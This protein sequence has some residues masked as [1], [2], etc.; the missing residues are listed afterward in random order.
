MFDLTRDYSCAVTAGPEH[1]DRGLRDGMRWI[2]VKA[3]ELGGQPLVFAPGRSNIRD[4]PL[5]EQ[6]T[7]LPGVAV[8]TW[9]SIPEWRG[10]PV[11]AAWPNRRKLGE[12]ADDSR[13]SALV[14]V[15]W[16]PG[17]LDSWIAA[18]NPEPLGPAVGPTAASSSSILDPVVL[19][20]LETLT[21][22]VNHAN[23]LAG[24]LDRRDAVAV[25]RTLSNAGYHL[26]PDAVYSWAFEHGWPAR[27]AERLRQL[28]ADF[29]A[30]KQPHMKGQFP[31]RADI[32]DTWRRA[33]RENR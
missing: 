30:G 29:E 13:T 8:G 25:L 5:L 33:A 10:G 6:F 17:E 4:V 15:P 28:A 31:F 1:G 20:G 21:A 3:R 19:Q 24:A 18:A 26:S 11:L 32:L 27:G 9:R 14:V 2:V 7:K 22:S 23:H 12:I 16:A